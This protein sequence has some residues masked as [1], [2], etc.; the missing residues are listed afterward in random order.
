MQ[1]DNFVPNPVFTAGS[2]GP[3]TSGVAPSLTIPEQPKSKMKK[4]I[5]LSAIG[6]VVAAII[7]FVLI[8]LMAINGKMNKEEAAE[9]YRV[10]GVSFSE[11]RD[12]LEDMLNDEQ[13]LSD[14]GIQIDDGL[15]SLAKIKETLEPT[16]E[17]SGLKFSSGDQN[18]D[19]TKLQVEIKSMLSSYDEIYGVLKNFNV[20]FFEPA[21]RMNRMTSADYDITREDYEFI[22]GYS[23]NETANSLLK[24]ENSDQKNIASQLSAKVVAKARVMNSLVQNNC[25]SDSKN[26]CVGLYEEFNA[27][28]E[29]ESTIPTLVKEIVLAQNSSARSMFEETKIL[30][31]E[32]SVFVEGLE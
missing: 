16:L 24:A 21:N 26:S 5:L 6:I 23:P 30:Q 25:T 32:I 17:F 2:T 18:D 4:I 8:W 13:S 11:P 20:A 19:F 7:V 10:I 27:I 3:L 15:R 22:K 29:F 31:S 12:L 1:S 28:L 9:A 14:A